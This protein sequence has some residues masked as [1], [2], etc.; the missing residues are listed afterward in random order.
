MNSS[1]KRLNNDRNA[2]L[3]YID[4][5]QEDIIYLPSRRDLKNHVQSA[6][7]P[8]E[9]IQDG[10]SKGNGDDESFNR[11]PGYKFG[12]QEDIFLSEDSE[13]RGW[14]PAV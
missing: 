9:M 13:G 4:D 11:E 8:P 14:T 6:R 10:S 5:P 12:K 2:S 1:F 7:F 3:N